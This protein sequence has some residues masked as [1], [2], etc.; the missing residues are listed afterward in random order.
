MTEAERIKAVF[1]RAYEPVQVQ[2]QEWTLADCMMLELE[3][4]AERLQKLLKAIT[5]AQL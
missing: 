4:K 2:R 1:P 3:L 5:E